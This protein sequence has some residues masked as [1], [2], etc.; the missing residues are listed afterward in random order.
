M[1]SDHD[2]TITVKD[3][4]FLK[5]ALNPSDRV[6]RKI[7]L[8]KRLLKKGMPLYKAIRKAGLGWKNY[9]KY[10]PLIYDD[11]E[12]LVPLPKTILKDYKYRIDVESIRIVLD[13]VAKLAAAKL[14]RD[15]LSGK[16]G[17]KELWWNVKENPGKHWLRLCRD[18]QLVWMREL[19]VYI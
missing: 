8:V 9:Y 11:P 17:K 1:V 13:G 5:S 16:R 14:I 6:I 15:I 2:N 4:E 3:L 12:I 10:A 19:C 18:L 7:V